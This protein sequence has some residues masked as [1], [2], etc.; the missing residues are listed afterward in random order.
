M[1]RALVLIAVVGGSAT[2]AQADVAGLNFWDARLEFGVFADGGT[3]G[4]P[5]QGLAGLSPG[6]ATR[7][8]E[9][10]D[11]IAH[12]QVRAESTLT[13]VQ[14]PTRLWVSLEIATVSQATVGDNPLYELE[15]GVAEARLE[16]AVFDVT[17]LEPSLLTVAGAQFGA[18]DVGTHLLEPGDYSL[19]LSGALARSNVDVGVNAASVHSA[20]LLA[21]FEITPV[22][23]PGGAAMLALLGAASLR[24]RP[25]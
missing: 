10:T 18:Y 12:A 5:D 6:L 25:R 13:L 23:A 11:G 2:G 4:S 7:L 21:S 17:V 9:M 15:R 22:P 14:A 20:F 3:C 19:D 8:W 1:R 24:R 16:S